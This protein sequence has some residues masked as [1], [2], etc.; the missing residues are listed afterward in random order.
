MLEKIFMTDPLIDDVKALLDKGF[1][2]DRIL[3]QILRACENDEVI[4]NYERNYVKKL[5]EKHLRKKPEP[6]QTPLVE[7]KPIIPDV[8]MPTHQSTPKTQSP[9]HTSSKITF[10]PSKN[11]KMFL[12]LGGVVL[13][14][15]VVIAV[16]FNGVSDTSSNA[17]SST[18]VPTSLSIQTDLSSYHKKDLI[19]INGISNVP[20]YV[21]L[22][23]ENQK[24][25]L[26]WAEQLSL[27]PN[28]SFSTLAIA[29]GP[30]W[31]NSGTYTIKVDNG[32]ESKSNSF[33]FT[34]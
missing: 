26:V 20:G 2:D 34:T 6:V 28:G 13:A 3:K 22:S 7:E 5:I 31:E 4:S 32:V 24:N 12:G 10:N 19:A 1:E 11:S 14:I 30:G 23:I 25:E 18:A 27:K 15:I 33:L 9:Q 16:S 17:S 8:I 29:G 21:N